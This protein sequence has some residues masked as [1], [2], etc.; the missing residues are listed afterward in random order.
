MARSGIELQKER[1][2][3]CIRGSGLGLDPAVGAPARRSARRGEGILER[4]A[5]SSA[6]TNHH[7]LVISATR[8]QIPPRF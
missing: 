2:L 5:G 7:R 4:L 8:F 3:H 6:F 1:M